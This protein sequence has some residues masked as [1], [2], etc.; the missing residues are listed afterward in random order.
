LS[1]N[2]VGNWF[3]TRVFIPSWSRLDD[4]AGVSLDELPSSIVF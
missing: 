3:H 4:H 1:V 2:V